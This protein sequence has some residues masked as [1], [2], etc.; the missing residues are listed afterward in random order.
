MSST[1]VWMPK[2]W[3]ARGP[4]MVAPRSAYVAPTLMVA[5]LSPLIVKIGGP[6]VA[7]AATSGMVAGAP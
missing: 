6:L 4:V 3:S 2:F 5:G 7:L 1:K